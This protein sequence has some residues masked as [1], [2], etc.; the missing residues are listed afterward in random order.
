MART[1]QFTFSGDYVDLVADV[2]APNLEAAV[3]LMRRMAAHTCD[4]DD[5]STLDVTRNGVY[6]RAWLKIRPDQVTQAP[7][8]LVEEGD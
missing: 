3:E 7:V 6:L 2:E 5:P 4:S 1:Y 8:H